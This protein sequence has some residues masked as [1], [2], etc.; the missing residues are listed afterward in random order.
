MLG[1]AADEKPLSREQGK[2]RACGAEIL[3]PGW[4][5]NATRCTFGCCSGETCFTCFSIFLRTRVSPVCESTNVP[6]ALGSDGEKFYH[7]P[8]RA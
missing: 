2:C 3:G 8:P 4:V 1:K 7:R 6:W 5:E